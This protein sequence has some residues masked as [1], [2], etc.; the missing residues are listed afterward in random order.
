MQC[1]TELGSEFHLQVPENQHFTPITMLDWFHYLKLE[2]QLFAYFN[3]N[4]YAAL[5]PLL[6]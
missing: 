1:D 3:D 6:M 4:V 2:R 5:H